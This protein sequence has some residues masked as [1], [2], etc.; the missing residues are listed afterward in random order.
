MLSP[1]CPKS[2]SV[3]KN[4]CVKQVKKLSEMGVNWVTWWHRLEGES[5]F[6]FSL[7]FLLNIRIFHS[8]RRRK[9]FSSK[10]QLVYPPIVT[11]CDI[12]S[13]PLISMT[14]YASSYLLDAQ[15]ASSFNNV[16]EASRKGRSGEDCA[17]LYTACN[18]TDWIRYSSHSFLLSFSV[19]WICE[20]MGERMK[21]LLDSWGCNI[22]WCSLLDIFVFGAFNLKREWRNS[23]FPIHT[24]SIHFSIRSLTPFFH[25]KKFTAVTHKHLS[26]HR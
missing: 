3:H 15:K 19:N 17:K 8:F 4:I 12:V 10:T 26:K 22:S 7:F 23:F 13:L 25:C 14:S 18:E 16:Y 2:L 20:R 1:P 24:Q 9:N 6:S 21:I 5:L 11:N